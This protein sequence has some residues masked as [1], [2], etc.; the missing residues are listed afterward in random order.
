VSKVYPK[1][2]S[3][4]IAIPVDKALLVLEEVGQQKI[5]NVLIYSAGFKEMGQEGTANENRLL[6]ISQ[7]YDL[8]IMG[9]NCL[10]FLN[11]EI[12]LNATFGQAPSQ[13]GNL[14]I[15]SQSGAIA[16]SFFDWAANHS[17]GINQFISLGNKSWT[18]F[19]EFGRTTTTGR[20]K[21][22][23]IIKSVSGWHV[24]ES[25]AD[26][27]ELLK[28][29]KNS[30][31]PIFL[32]K[33]GKS[34]EAASAMKS[35]TGSLA[36]AD[37]ILDTAL[38]EANIIR[39][40]TLEEFFNLAK[41]LSWEN[42]PIGPNVA[43]ISNAGGPG[44]ISA[45][46][47]ANSNLKLANLSPE[48]VQILSEKLP[49]SASLHNPID[50]LG[51]ALSDRFGGAIDAVLKEDDVHALIVLL[52]PQ[53][54]TQIKETAQIIG[55][56]SKEYQKPIYCSFIGGSQVGEGEKVL[57]QFKIPNF[58]FP[59]NAIRTLSQV[60]NWST[61][62]PLESIPFTPRSF[63]EVGQLY[64]SSQDCSNPA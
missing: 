24:F 14:K 7:R 9:P 53:I 60:Y 12:K 29:A 23:R 43:I 64:L 33:P 34:P 48:T 27:Q 4:I 44:V 15:L 17:L 42:A 22:R 58:N 11:N 63:S 38:K 18:S 50:V 62:K 52:T 30:S 13:N 51:D 45:D 37:D 57:N 28:I 39:A 55:E 21:R 25:I 31:N 61:D 20:T 1:H 59:E 2:R 41:A 56:K 35:H 8:N 49:R 32:L 6:E 40:N 26:G 10:G 5:K 47:I 16:T 46:A 19:L 36:G 54:M 3:V